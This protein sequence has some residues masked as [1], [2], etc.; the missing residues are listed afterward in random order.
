[1]TLGPLNHPF[2]GKRGFQLSKMVWPTC[3]IPLAWSINGISPELTFWKEPYGVNMITLEP[4]AQPKHHEY[5]VEIAL[6]MARRWEPCF[7]GCF[8]GAL[9]YRK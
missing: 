3:R 9:S 8:S 5:F 7:G 6:G 4:I 1:M 2:V